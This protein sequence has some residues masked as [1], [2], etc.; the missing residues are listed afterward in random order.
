IV[1]TEVDLF[2][3][4]VATFTDADPN[5]TASD[6]SPTIT[7]GDGTTAAGDFSA[8]SRGGFSVVGSHI[9]AEEGSY[10][11][12]VNIQDA[13]GA[14]AS[15]TSLATVQDAPLTASNQSITATEGAAF[16]GLVATFTDANL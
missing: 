12:R 6:Y 2:A 1:T 11:V 13:G 3:G 8:D 7:W 15:T 16:N 14:A 10:A 4:I 9:Y 5:G